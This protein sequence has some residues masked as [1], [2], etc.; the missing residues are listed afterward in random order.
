MA[1][2]KKSYKKTTKRNYRRKF[3]GKKRYQKP[4]EVIVHKMSG[5]PDA[6]LIKLS[7][8][9]QINPAAGT[10]VLDW[11]FR[12]NSIYH[13]DLTGSG[14]TN[15]LY[16][17]QWAAFYS[18]YRVYGSKITVDGVSRDGTIACQL[19]VLPRDDT[20]TLTFIKAQEYGRTARS[21]MMP[22]SQQYPVRVHN[23]CS[24]R[25]AMGLSKSEVDSEFDLTGSLIAPSIPNQGWW[26]HVVTEQADGATGHLDAILSL[27]ITYYVKLYEV[28][29]V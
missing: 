7:Y 14:T 10:G 11:V 15:V 26:W 13:P 2:T 23:Y 12:G 20:A 3:K 21:K 8:F 19:V 9:Q 6:I 22:I 5:V 27:K 4:S 28:I 17:A 25:Q 29:N 16:F 1:Y 24:T 18:R